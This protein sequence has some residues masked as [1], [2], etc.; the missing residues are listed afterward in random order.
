MGID[1]V[2]HGMAVTIPK[3]LAFPI[4]PPLEALSTDRISGCGVDPGLERQNHSV[5][6][7]KVKDR[8]TFEKETI[9]WPRSLL[10]E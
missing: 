3:R 10:Q 1:P 4:E 2:L 6:S 9:R 7:G 5:V 8:S